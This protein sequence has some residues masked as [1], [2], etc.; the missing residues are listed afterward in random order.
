MFI[1][2]NHNLNKLKM[3]MK[4]EIKNQK[5]QMCLIE[6]ADYQLVKMKVQFKVQELIKQMKQKKIKKKVFDI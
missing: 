3:L 6:Q 5:T 2:K 1:Q 4:V